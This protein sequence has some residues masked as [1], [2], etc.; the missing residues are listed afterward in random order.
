[1]DYIKEYDLLLLD[2]HLNKVTSNNQVLNG[3]DLTKILINNNINIKLLVLTADTN[4]K[5]I[6]YL[7]KRNIKYLNKPLD[8]DLFSKAISKLGVII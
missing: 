5:T 8:L 2:W 3:I 7:N 6:E 4:R 1:M